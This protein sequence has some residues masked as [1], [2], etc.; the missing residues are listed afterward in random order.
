[1]GWNGSGGGSTPIKPKTTAKKPSPIRGIVA[2]AAVCILAIGA[3]FAFFSGGEKPQKE[4]AAKE[5]GRIKEVTPAA[6][7][8][9]VEEAPKGPKVEIRKLENG[10]LMKYRDG[11]PAWLYPRQPPTAVVITNSPT[12]SREEKIFHNGAEA[13]IA[14]LLNVEPGEGLVG[15]SDSLFGEPFRKRLMQSFVEPTLVLHDDPED[16]K[17]LK[18]AVNEVKAELKQRMDAG[19]DPCKILAETRE[20]LR[21]LGAYRQELQAELRK[22]AKENKDLSPED[23]EDYVSAANKMLEERGAKK[24]TLP[25]FFMKQAEMRAAER[26]RLQETNN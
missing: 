14:M 24:V 8:K 23:L 25:T 2:G 22:I 4:T 11:K 13:Q 9:A 18:R 1:M 3:Y 19:E 15:D 20:D 5:R 21:Q 16:V 7:P 12:P 26:Q 17:E 10:M 6:A